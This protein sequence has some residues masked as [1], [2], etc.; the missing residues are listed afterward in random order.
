MG[1][2]IPYGALYLVLHIHHPR[3]ELDPATELHRELDQPIKFHR[4]LDQPT[5]FGWD[6]DPRKNSSNT[7]RPN[8]QYNILLVYYILSSGKSSGKHIRTSRYSY[9][10]TSY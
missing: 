2:P 5:K 3:M 4:E 9:R 6:L 1:D 8:S 10:T 7:S